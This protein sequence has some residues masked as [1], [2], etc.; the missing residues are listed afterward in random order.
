MNS[1]GQD[2]TAIATNDPA[3]WNEIPSFW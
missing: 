1:L 2:T 3:T